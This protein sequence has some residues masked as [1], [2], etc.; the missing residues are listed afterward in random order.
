MS[1]IVKRANIKHKLE[2]IFTILTDKTTCVKHKAKMNKQT[3]LRIFKHLT[4][5]VLQTF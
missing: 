4:Y 3:D 5:I 2:E 1:Q